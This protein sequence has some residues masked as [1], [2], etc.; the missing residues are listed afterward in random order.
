MKFHILTIFPEMFKGFLNESILKKAQGKGVI[1]IKLHNIRKYSKDKHK[2]VDDTPYGGGAG[3]VFTPQPLF[4]CIEHV[5]SK[6]KARGDIPVIYLTPG[7]KRLTQTQVERFAKKYDQLILL[8]GH[9]EG[10]DQ[11]VIDSLVDVEL[12]IGDYVLSG[13]EVPAMVVVDAVSRLV[14]GAIGKEE[15]H[16]EE[17]FSKK[18]GRKKEYPH[19]TKPAEFRGMEVPEVLLGGNH[20]EIERWRRKHLR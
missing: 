8:C 9:Y 20:A 19:Y 6:A 1:E 15:S 12:S 2:K 11:R 17:S 3:M 7:G 4:D 10:I 16:Q 5:K 18:L 14:P 13:G